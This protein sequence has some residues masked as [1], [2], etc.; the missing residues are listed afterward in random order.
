MKEPELAA[1]YPAIAGSYRVRGYVIIL[2]AFATSEAS[3]VKALV[4]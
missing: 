2:S 1:S 3:F 4:P